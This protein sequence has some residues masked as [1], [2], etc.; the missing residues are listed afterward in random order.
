MAQSSAVLVDQIKTCI[1]D[2]ANTTITDNIANNIVR[3]FN[4]WAYKREQPSDPNLMRQFVA[5]AVERG[6]PVPFVLYW[7]KGPRSALATPDRQCL[8]YLAT[9]AQRVASAYAQG[10]CITL[11]CTD[12]HALLNGHSQRAIQ[13]YFGEIE[14]AAA[15]RGFASCRL[16]SIASTLPITQAVPADDVVDVETLQR[17]TRAATLWYRGGESA[18][19]GARRYYQMN[20]VEKRAIER[21][22][23]DA[24]FITFNGSEFRPLFPD[25]L[26]IFYMYS[27]KRGSAIKP[28]FAAETAL[29]DV[30]SLALSMK[31]NGYAQVEF[32]S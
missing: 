13:E 23:P 1:N 30:P 11:V 15:K 19:V 10:V 22:Y 7:G 6:E 18:E 26:P 28:W 24:I 3:S 20:M 31:P 2:G 17:L 16:G 4:T 27:L 9:L 8:N 29:D 14:R 25:G 32:V 12:T 5:R 21:A